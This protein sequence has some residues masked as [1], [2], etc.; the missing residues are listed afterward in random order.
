MKK[1]LW[2]IILVL[3]MIGSYEA[4]SFGERSGIMARK[5]IDSAG[6]ADNQAFIAQE[7]SPVDPLLLAKSK[8]ELK[9]L[10]QCSKTRYTCE[11]D[12]NGK[13]KIGTENNWKESTKCQ[14]KYNDCMAK[15]EL[16]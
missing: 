15:C 8:E 1:F 14:G 4:P 12:N 2:G 13:N 16:S 10:E 11:K 5:F 6:I 3:A 9:C 7:K